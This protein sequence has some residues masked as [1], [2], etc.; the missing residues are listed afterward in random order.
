MEENNVYLI[1]L[2]ALKNEIFKGRKGSQLVIFYWTSE[3]AVQDFLM[4]WS[5][6]GHVMAISKDDLEYAC[7]TQ[8][9]LCAE[10]NFDP[11]E[12]L[13]IH[14]QYK[15]EDVEFYRNFL[16]QSYEKTKDIEVVK[17][18]NSGTP[19]RKKSVV[20]GVVLIVAACVFT[21]VW[22]FGLTSLIGTFL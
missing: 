20:K 14:Y 13:E 8:G 12:E 6:P 4:T 5:I 17:Q 10:A 15:E 2:P 21:W 18:Y 7:H 11:E 19:R 16:E 9:V 22:F 1:T 3:Q